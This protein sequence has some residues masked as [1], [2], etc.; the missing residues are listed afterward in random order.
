MTPET[1]A[2]AELAD[3]L[4]RIQ[5]RGRLP[6]SFGKMKSG[7][8][9]MAAM[10]ATRSPF[11]TPESHRV[12]VAQNAQRFESQ[13]EKIHTQALSEFTTESGRISAQIVERLGLKPSKFGAEL[14]GV[15]LQMP[16]NAARIEWLSEAMK[17]ATNAPLLQDLLESPSALHGV[18]VDALRSIEK[19]FIER[20]APDLVAQQRDLEDALSIISSIH[21]TAARMA[22]S[23]QDHAELARIEAD[24]LRAEEANNQM[25]KALA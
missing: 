11:E 25:Q 14:R 22:A 7:I 3:R 9:S 8:D 4:Q 13:L 18:P 24:R 5:H 15:L 17:D 12:K 16:T 10:A 21:R 1:R 20:N 2:A 23:H 6:E 19:D